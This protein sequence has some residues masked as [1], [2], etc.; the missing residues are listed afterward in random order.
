MLNE[1]ILFLV[2]SEFPFDKIKDQLKNHKN[3]IIISFDVM[4]HKKLENL[5]LEH[6]I[7]DN[8]LSE[9][10]IDEAQHR[11][12]FFGKWYE[13]PE[14]KKYLM[15]EN[16]NVGQLFHEQTVVFLSQF[17][18][19]FYEIENIIKKYPDSKF[20]ATSQI[21]QISKIFSSL[22]I[23]IQNSENKNVEF[24]HDKVRYNIKIGKKYFL[25]LIPKNYYLKIKKISEYFYNK[26]F[27][28]NKN[29]P[30]TNDLILLVEFHTI[31]F[32]ELFLQSKI[33]PLLVYFGRRRPAIWNNES[34]SI[35]RRSK[36]KIITSNLLPIS[37][38]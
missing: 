27:G 30:K 12:Y 7:S 21:F 16:V 13:N 24:V 8:Y 34:L 14:I 38:Y 6:K 32:K 15:Y 9:N 25:F 4:S 1:P 29:I 11:T 31:R 17:F 26:I 20:I 19:K 10:E 3:H 36:S 33:N 28:F 18:K 35:F 37:D 22:G 23:E 5:G 2:D